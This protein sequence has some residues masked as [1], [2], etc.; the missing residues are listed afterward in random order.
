MKT[1]GIVLQSFG[2][3]GYH[4]AA[5]NL[6]ASIKHHNPTLSIT[7]LRHEGQLE[8]LRSDTPNF[9]DNVIDLPDSVVH[10][11]A[12]AKIEVLNKLPYDH[13]LVLD[14]DALCMADLEPLLDTFIRSKKHFIT[15]ITGEGKKGEEIPY[16]IWAKHEDSFKFFGLKDTDTWYTT[17]TS[18][19]YAVKGAKVDKLYTELRK[20]FDKGFDKN[21]LKNKWGRYMPDELYFSGVLSKLKINAKTE[22]K[23]MFFGSKVME[24]SELNKYYIMS[25]YGAGTGT[26]TTRM[27]YWEH[28]D[29]MMQQV[30]R[31]H[32]YR[33]VYKGS[34]IQEHKIVNHV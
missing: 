18:W 30:M 17:Q 23:P 12:L 20:Y 5:V 32:G 33:H 13:N 11:P 24:L 8:Y 25:L 16:D 21:K 10:N 31:A 34:Y 4:Y 29:R 9:F 28:Y 2:N 1:K 15:E 3:Y 27:M 19:F 22:E 14:V 26:T 6:A 7:W